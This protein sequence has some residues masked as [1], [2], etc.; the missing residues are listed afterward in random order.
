MITLNEDG[1]ILSEEDLSS[2]SGFSYTLPDRNMN[3]I[4]SNEIYLYFYIK[5]LEWQFLTKNS[6]ES[7]EE[8]TPYKY[9]FLWKYHV[10]SYGVLKKTIHH[11]VNFIFGSLFVFFCFFLTP[12]VFVFLCSKIF[13][14]NSGNCK[15]ERLVDIVIVRS[16]AT[17][18]KFKNILNTKGI[19]A[20]SEDVTYKNSE[21]D[22]I[23]KYLS[24][25]D[26]LKV[27]WRFPFRCVEHIYK[28]SVD[29]S[30]VF[31]SVELTYILRLYF[32]RVLLS[33]LYY[34]LFECLIISNS[35]N[36]VYTGNKED[37]FALIEQ[38][39]TTKLS[40]KLICIPHGLEYGFA[41][42]RGIV[43][44]TVF[45][46]TL[47]SSQVLSYLYPFQKIIFD[48]NVSRLMFS[49][50]SRA[51]TYS[52]HK[53][54]VFFTEARG[55]DINIRIMKMIMNTGCDF[56]VKLHPKDSKSNYNDLGVKFI[57]D[58]HVAITNSICMARKSTVLLESKFNNSC[59]IACVIDS[60]DKFYVE[61]VFPS[62]SEDIKQ[63]SCES[64][65]SYLLKVNS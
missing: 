31:T 30:A 25:F 54:I 36:T 44:N 59:S 1:N 6:T 53:K 16:P 65:F 34:E 11:I 7:Y 63:F 46:T 21:I 35:V 33:A 52:E 18:S 17:Y 20:L 23:F 28:L 51:V 27:I 38:E 37:R 10:F 2:L 50:I 61:T 56:F 5:I 41:T 47:K 49:S 22:S 58:F 39:V 4:F 12:V 9:A 48:E 40:L 62:L 45:A 19:K 60:T 24:Y 15:D 3:S 32:F 13:F 14:S 64:D 29:V 43:G 8:S 42:P 57:E 55:I 26:L